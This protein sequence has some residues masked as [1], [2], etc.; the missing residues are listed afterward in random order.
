[1]TGRTLK[2]IAALLLLVPVAVLF[3]VE[4][5]RVGS[6][7][8]FG[9][10]ISIGSEAT[11]GD[12]TTEA[13]EPPQFTVRVLR[14]FDGP[15]AAAGLQP[16]DRLVRIG[17]VDVD[18][19]FLALGR[20]LARHVPG[21]ALVLV[22]RRDGAVREL[23]LTPPA[24]WERPE[25]VVGLVNRVLAALVFVGIGLLLVIRRPA[26]RTARL[27][28]YV[29]IALAVIMLTSMQW[30]MP[31][32]AGPF[33]SFALTEG[34]GFVLS[35]VVMI[36]GALLSAVLMLHFALVFP[37]TS[38]LVERWPFIVRWCYALPLG[39]LVLSFALLGGFALGVAVGEDAR[40]VSHVAAA[41]I[42]GL[43]A[44]G[45]WLIVKL[46]RALREGVVAALGRAGSIVALALVLCTLL[47]A[48]LIWV[49][50]PLGQGFVAGLLA[51]LPAAAAFFV[52][53]LFYPLLTIAALVHAY[54]R[55][56]MEGRRQI[57]WPLWAIVVALGGSLLLV[58][59]MMA[60]M[61][62]LVAVTV[63]EVV[64]TLLYLLIPVGFMVGILKYRLFDIEVV[65]RQTAIYTATTGAIIALFVLIAGG[66]GGLVVQYV[67]IESEWVTAFATLA[68]A[69]ALVPV[70]RNVRRGVE[71]IF[72]RR[73]IAYPEALASLDAA[74]RE[75]TDE[76]VLAR[77]ALEQVG[78]ALP[79]RGIALLLLVER[80]ASYRPA[81]TLGLSDQVVRRLALPAPAR[82]PRLLRG[83]A[84]LEGDLTETEAEA[85]GAARL[86]RGAGP[87]D[88]QHNEAL[89]LVG[90]PTR[91]ADFDE[92][93]DAFLVEVVERV[94]ERVRE[95]RL[96][97]QQSDLARAREIQE[98]LLPVSLPKAEGLD[99]AHAWQPARRIGGDYFDVLDLGEGR[100]GVCIADV[101]GKGISAALLMSNLQAVFRATAQPATTPAEACRAIN[102][103]LAVQGA[104][105]RFVTFFYAIVDRPGQTVRYCSAGH[106]P[107][108]LVRANGE[109]LRLREGGPVLGIIEEA[110]FDEGEAVF[111]TG[112]RLV[113]FTDGLCEARNAAGEEFGEERIG[114]LVAQARAD[115]SAPLRDAL[116]AAALEWSD[117]EPGD[118]LTLLVL[119]AR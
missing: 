7:P 114:R 77:V 22:V 1:M 34:G 89:L 108:V 52:F 38:P 90:P 46:V 15:A 69:G 57:W 92:Q 21:R 112:D 50:A 116:L 95:L 80:D 97:A 30:G 20:E 9:W 58:P 115:G 101:S 79:C 118:D 65:V 39:S 72:F 87:A 17:D 75:V 6:R 103:L 102:R 59:P 66:V 12:E 18:E 70:H 10:S 71:R 119:A 83:A 28:F 32:Q 35:F 64:S 37:Q 45:L 104:T 42:A 113:L 88:L 82:L 105:G 16:G 2:T 40:P 62:D 60:L 53:A 107:P 68:V 63:I 31:W 56:G 93:D 19:G 26:L 98:R 91:A 94:A 13:G 49:D 61:G 106:N 78:R 25:F 84:P 44:C 36:L 85:L 76:D 51:A 23:T 110:D 111:A 54:V 109:I 86:V 117:G 4:T 5:V 48:G 73:R 81:A 24:H 43:A 33:A 99:L 41:V 67:A 11:R 55:S 8:W 3:V 27:F 74:A 29:C 47:A 100:L 14:V 96:S